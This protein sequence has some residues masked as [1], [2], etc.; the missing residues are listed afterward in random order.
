MVEGH[1]GLRSV[2]CPAFEGFLINMEKNC[3]LKLNPE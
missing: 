1:A 3:S 2:D